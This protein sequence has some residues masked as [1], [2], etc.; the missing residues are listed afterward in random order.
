MHIFFAIT[1]TKKKM[2][3]TATNIAIIRIDI[4]ANKKELVKFPDF[5]TIAVSKPLY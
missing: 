4:N 5:D 1:A 3:K 2:V